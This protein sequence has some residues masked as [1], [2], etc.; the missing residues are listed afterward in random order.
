MRKEIKYL[1]LLL[2]AALFLGGLN[3]LLHMQPSSSGTTNSTGCSAFQLQGNQDIQ[4]SPYFAAPDVY[5]LQ[6]NDHLTVLSHFKTRQQSTG[7]TCAPVA[8]A[9]VVE[10]FLGRLPHTEEEIAA[11]MQSNNLNGTTIK[12]VANYFTSLGW[13][14]Q[15]SSNST[16]P[17]NFASFRQFV[18]QAL[19]SNTPIIIENVEWGGHY[20]VII[21][22]DTMGTDYPGDDVVI[23][24]DSFDLA[25]HVQD[26]YNIEN[27]QKLYY[28][29]FDAQLFSRSEQKN[30]WLIAKPQ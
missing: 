21:G 9:M 15:S 7:Y 5:N 29:W 19:R 12:G 18:Q 3:Y 16:T 26:G 6:S 11:I 1:F 28:M 4:T 23:L 27:A 14:V 24:A 10:H 17:A 8:A 25:D 13:Q 20:R 30:P 22:Y 2:G